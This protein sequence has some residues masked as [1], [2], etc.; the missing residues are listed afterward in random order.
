MS[1][2]PSLPLC[3]SA[4]LSLALGACAT[5]DV[6]VWNLEQL[7]DGDTRHRYQ[8]A[9]QSDTGYFLRH[10]LLGIFQGAGVQA[11]AEKDL[12]AVED[13]AGECLGNLIEL[14]DRARGE[15]EPDPRHVE[16]F[17]RIAVEDTSRLSR[18]RAV[19]ALEE[20]GGRLPVGLPA[21]L[22]MD[23]KPAGPEELAPVLEE[24]VRTVRG[25]VETRAGAAEKVGQSCAAV[26]ALDLDLAAG[27]RALR[28]AT[29]LERL[30]VSGDA[31]SAELR[32]LV[33]HLE[34]LCVRRALAAALEDKDEI[35]RAAAIRGVARTGGARAFDVVL[36]DRLRQET[37]TRPLRALLEVIAEQGLPKPEP[38][39]AKPAHSA[40][41]WIASIQVIAVQHPE[42][43]LRVRAMRT[44]QVVAAPELKSLR[45]ED[46]Y[47]WGM[48]RKAA[49]NQP[50]TAPASRPAGQAGTPP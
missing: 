6:K 9:L 41:D 45:E 35:V 38:G 32:D 49:A 15:T 2:F 40:E 5:T 3:G 29:E 30:A 17:A 27:R 14:Q 12:E 1:R 8:A 28:A 10:Q 18:E 4:A 37:S 23:Q 7:H 13:P 39:G 11:V 42:G 44:L 26:R 16:W 24:L 48:A 21:R 19:L 34:S 36:Y 20:M 22:G 47:A 33:R 46:W 31:P 50:A 43:E 25:L